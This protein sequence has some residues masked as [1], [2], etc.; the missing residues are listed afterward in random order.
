MQ[1][2]R[3]CFRLSASGGG[4]FRPA[5]R[6]AKERVRTESDEIASIATRKLSDGDQWE[7]TIYPYAYQKER[8]VPMRMIRDIC[9]A[10]RSQFESPEDVFDMLARAMFSGRVLQVL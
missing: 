10:H 9:K 7:S 2:R 4:L 6:F 5:K 8:R 3:E 1:P